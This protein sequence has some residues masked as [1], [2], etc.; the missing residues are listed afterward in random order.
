MPLEEIELPFQRREL[1]EEVAVF[2]QEA[3]ARIDDYVKRNAKTF[4]GFVAS[5]YETIYHALRAISD[6][7]LSSGHSFCE[8]GS[9]F[10]VVASLASMLEFN[11]CGIEIGRDL[12]DGAR[13]LAE[14]FELPVEFVHGSFI[15]RQGVSQA[16]QACAESSSEYFW[17][18]TDA[19]DAYD[20]LGF[21]QD[22]FDL[23]FAYP[24]PGEELVIDELFD[25]H[26]AAGALLLTHDQF[27]SVR[28]QRK[29]T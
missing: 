12:V 9:G 13:Q 11:A 8:W 21:D 15:P 5:N 18:V 26:A 19:D 6:R 25:S 29:V 3:D 16:E 7:R 2:L 10:G 4:N 27:D 23:I 1:P 22:D 28:L 20:E 14:D 17:L 24:W